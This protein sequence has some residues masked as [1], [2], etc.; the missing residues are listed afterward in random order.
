MKKDFTVLDMQKSPARSREGNK[1]CVF[2]EFYD[3]HDVW[4]FMSACA[5][6]FS[7]LVSYQNVLYLKTGVLY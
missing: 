1:E 5:L 7:F 2:L 3:Y 6:F 4:H